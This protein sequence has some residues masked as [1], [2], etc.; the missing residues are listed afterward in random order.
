MALSPDGE[1]LATA[2]EDATIKLWSINGDILQ[3]LVGHKSWIFHL[4]FSP[5]GETLASSSNDE[6]A[7]LWNLEALKFD[8]L[9]QRGCEWWREYTKYQNNPPDQQQT[10]CHGFED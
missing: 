8:A 4:E 2:G 9:M 10:I 5:D 7:I 6:T 3:T 1:T